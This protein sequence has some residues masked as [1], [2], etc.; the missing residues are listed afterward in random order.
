MSSAASAITPRVQSAA[1]SRR[2][3]SRAARFLLNLS[4][5]VWAWFDAAVIFLATYCAY[6]FMLDGN[7]EYR[8]VAGPWI[9]G[10]VFSGGIIFAGVVFGL[11]EQR[12]LGARSRIV[13]RGF[14]SLALGVTLAY[15]LLSV[16]LYLDTTRWLGLCVA[17]IYAAAAIPL[18]IAAHNA[19][20]TARLNVLC[21]GAGDSIRRVVEILGRGS[22]GHYRL[23]GYAEAPKVS[24]AAH[25][26]VDRRGTRALSGDLRA[27]CPR[28]GDVAEIERIL[29]RHAI[30]EVVVDVALTSHPAVGAAVLHC[31]DQHC[32]VTDQPTFVE[33]LLGETPIDNITAHWFLIADV[34]GTGSYDAVKRLVDTVAALVGLLVTLP[35]LPLIVL[36]IRL[37]SRGPAFYRQ[38]RLGQNGRP[39]RI[40]KFR[41][42]CNDAEADGA[43]WATP[44][45]ARVTR[46]GR[47]LRKSRIDEL[48]QLWNILTGDMSIVGP[49]PERPEFVE[50]LAEWIPHY[51]QRHLIK[52][53]LTGWAQIH[54]GYG[55]SVD[56]AQR[57]L[58]YDLYYLKHRSVDFDFAII[59]RTLGRFVFGAR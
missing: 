2:R 35:L 10:G 53:G 25:D 1:G 46:L 34:R 15:A 28:L 51:R 18:R 59:I 29:E 44:N 47:F 4:P 19:I 5:T 26:T 32:R 22:S 12:T 17:L 56:D 52:P 57:K 50:Q 43:R 39:F 8:W 23:V 30:D 11:Y 49:R 20:S 37:D 40:V 38:I 41:T 55:D 31:L 48:P 36:A 42:M 9:S 58:C 6:V 24:E 33:T 14:M 7:P 3:A 54:Y 13:V 16:F 45:D 27:D 21:L